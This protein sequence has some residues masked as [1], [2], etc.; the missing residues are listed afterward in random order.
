MSL[1]V[2]TDIPS[3]GGKLLPMEASWKRL[4]QSHILA[5]VETN[6]SE[7]KKQRS[8]PL[9]DDSIDWVPRW[10]TA[11][12]RR[13][14]NNNMI[15]Q[16]R[17]LCA[18]VGMSLVPLFL[19]T[20]NSL[21]AHRLAVAAQFTG[22]AVKP[23]LDDNCAICFFGLPRSFESLVLPSVITNILMP[24][25]DH[26]CDIFVHYYDIEEEEP[27]RASKGGR[28]DT[29]AVA[30]LK[31]KIDEIYAGDLGFAQKPDVIVVSD[32]E[33]TFWDA[34]RDALDE[35][36]HAKAPDGN[37]KY[38]PWK[39]KSY[40]WPTS[41]DNIVKQWHSIEGVWGA[42][43]K[44]GE[45]KQK[46]YSRVAMLRSDVVYV[47]PINIYETSKHLHDHSNEVAVIPKFATYPVNDRMMYGPYE[48]VKVWATERFS[49]LEQHAQDRPGYGMHSEKYL[50]DSIL[51]A[52]EDHGFRVEQSPHICFF[53]ARADGQVH[54]NDCDDN[55]R[56]HPISFRR[57]QQWVEEASNVTCTGQVGEKRTLYKRV[58]C[59]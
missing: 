51:P 53:R 4:H 45:A 40:I 39:D 25:I 44:H 16:F 2:K 23:E 19:R 8:V 1:Y 13:R 57:K 52:I 42:M 56:F 33:D 31:D 46:N 7:R 27:G 6:G 54:L 35:Y 11:Y 28:I 49:R 5:L 47:T 58:N 22:A 48:A 26:G 3:S 30:N 34:R 24:N 59:D 15:L 32:T 50:A 55:S 41:T 14:F 29:T 12:D 21:A 43:T 37:F 20:T 10:L 38:F 36:R 9:R 18:L 17:A